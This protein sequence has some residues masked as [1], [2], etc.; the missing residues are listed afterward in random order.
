M[1]R[2]RQLPLCFLSA[3][4]STSSMRWVRALETAL[5]LSLANVPELPGRTLILVDRSGSM[6]YSRLSKQSGLTLADATAVFGSV[7]ALRA[8]QADLVE[9]G[10]GSQPVRFR[11]GDSVLKLAAR[12]GDLGGTQTAEAVRRHFRRQDRVVI[13]TDEQAWPGYGRDP[14]DY[15]PLEVPA[16]TFNP[17]GYRYGHGPSG[18]LNRHT[19]GGLTDHAFAAIPL[20]EAGL[21]A[22]WPWAARN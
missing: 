4:R 9:F 14:L 22:E 19:F 15:V 11:R 6:F 13:L 5:Q 3:Y 7:L 1:A 16:Y 17:A 8:Q 12:F 10:T 18:S 20:L 2:S 21:N